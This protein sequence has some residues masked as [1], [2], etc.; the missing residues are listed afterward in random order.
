L[1]NP[2][3]KTQIDKII[4]LT[5]EAGE[6]AARAF[7][8]KNFSVAVKSDGSKVSSADI[9]VSEFLREN[10]AK[11]FSQIII[12]E[13]GSIRE[14]FDQDFFLIDPI[15][16]TS[17]FISGSNEFCIS[18]AF[19]QNN[20]AVFGVIYAPLFEDGKMIFSDE[21]NRVVMRTKN[22]EEKILSAEN[23][24]VNPL[25]IITSA[26]SKD[27]DVENYVKQILPNFAQN[28]HVEK[29]SSAIKFFRLLEG[30]ANLYLHF[31]PSMEWD[32][33]AGQIL[34]ELM[35]GKVK[36][37]SFNQSKFLIEGDLIYRKQSFENRAFVAFI[38]S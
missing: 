23:Y 31:R 13:E 17:S 35:G 11:D 24:S 38:K 7:E 33:A 9:A 12:C 26:R 8:A 22:G 36:N 27:H 5:L 15:D 28:F 29:L 6:I 20:K 3:N 21:K 2:F 19:V 14:T 30:D 16:G 34:V 18:I 37:L 25:K 1:T 4:A 10:L 32:I